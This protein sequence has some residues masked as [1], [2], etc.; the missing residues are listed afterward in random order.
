MNNSIF[1][2]PINPLVAIIFIVIVLLMIFIES[3]QH[4][5]KI[6]T[7]K[8]ETIAKATRFKNMNKSRDLCFYFYCNGEKTLGRTSG[9][10]LQSSVLDKFYQI[11][12]N[13]NNPLENEIILENEITP[14]SI[15]LIK[16]GFKYVKFHKLNISTNTY[17]E[18]WKW[19]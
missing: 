9:H 2:K 13:D 5:A 6:K 19:E 4:K 14:D 3:Q 15:T 11:K 7:F 10:D 16:S 18:N 12:F 8:S 17:E 1:K